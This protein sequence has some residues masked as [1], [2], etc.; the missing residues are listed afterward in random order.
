M[1]SKTTVVINHIASVT[2]RSLTTRLVFTTAI[3]VLVS[4]S[5]TLAAYTFLTVSGN[6]I[7]GNPAFSQFAGANG[8]ILVTH[9]FS[10]GGAG[11]QDNLNSAIIPSNF[12]T[13]PAFTG[14]GNVDGHLAQTQYGATSKVTFTMAYAITPNTV[15]GMWNTTDEV[16]QPAYRIE[17]INASNVAVPPTTFNQVGTGDNTGAAGVQGRHQMVMNP[18]TGDVSFGAV[19]NGGSG[20]HTNALFWDKIPPGTKAINVYG[21]LG[22]LP[23]NNVGDGVGYYFAEL[24]PEPGSM[25]LGA[26]G[27]CFA[28]MLR[29]R[30]RG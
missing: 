18:A 11:P 19:I 4:T 8:T 16:A 17:L 27:L 14:T 13:I 1:F 7:P 28:G 3:A 29:S 20:I 12:S 22:Q 10:A 9:S 21:T 6:N 2:T 23:G 24:V 15:F 5:T 30:R 26:I 25:M